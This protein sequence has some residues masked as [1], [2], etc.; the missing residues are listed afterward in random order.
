M[1]VIL[2]VTITHDIP[3]VSSGRFG[4]LRAPS[5]AKTSIGSRQGES[6]RAALDYLFLKSDSTHPFFGAPQ[7]AD[8][9]G[10]TH[11]PAHSLPSI[12]GAQRRA[13]AFPFQKYHPALGRRCVR[14][15]NARVSIFRVRASRVQHSRGPEFATE[16]NKYWFV[17][18]PPPW[19][20]PPGAQIP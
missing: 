12:Y 15:A 2:E 13:G 17:F 8:D 3:L 5:S 16:P 7:S 19:C 20:P 1:L 11:P 10:D 6:A 14:Q 9:F 4:L 18:S